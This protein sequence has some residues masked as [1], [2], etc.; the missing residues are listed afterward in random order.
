[1][2]NIGKSYRELVMDELYNQCVR[3]FVLRTID[4]IKQKSDAQHHARAG[5][6]K[7]KMPR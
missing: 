6:L 5:Y 4:H 7:P 1:M 2:G 3:P